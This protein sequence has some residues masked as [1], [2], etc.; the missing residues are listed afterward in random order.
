[1]GPAI[2]SI[3][4]LDG[5]ETRLIRAG[6]ELVGRTMRILS[7][8]F[9]RKWKKS[10]SQCGEDIIVG[11]VLDGLGIAKPT[12]LDIGSHDPVVLNNTYSLYA[13]GC[14][15]VC[16]EPAQA[17][18]QRLARKR[19]RDICLNAGVGTANEKEAE[20]YMLSPDT[21]STFSK[22]TAES[23][24][25]NEGARLVRVV[26][27]PLL[28]INDIIQDHFSG[29]PNLISLDTEGT[30]R[31]VLETFDFGRFRPEI[32]CVETLKYTNERI[33]SKPPDTLD[34]MA[35]NDYFLFADTWINSIFV[36]KRAWNKFL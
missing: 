11:L 19:K 25:T 26:K 2:R 3:P 5:K 13:R 4:S 29:S 6:H 36:D 17:L 9:G 21:L 16:V 24:V 20:F 10:Y 34:L 32:F 31:E 14:S 7:K 35:S 33:T 1:V 8:L 27:V 22:Q 30:E 23:Y 12:Y 15:G 28:I 18:F